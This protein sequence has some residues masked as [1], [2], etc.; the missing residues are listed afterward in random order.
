MSSMTTRVKTPRK[1]PKELVDAIAGLKKFDE[2]FYVNLT[3][4]QRE[5]EYKKQ[6]KIYDLGEK[7]GL[8][9]SYIKE[10]LDQYHTVQVPCHDCKQKQVGVILHGEGG[11]Y[12]YMV[13][14]CSEC[15]E[16]Q[17][18][19][20]WKERKENARIEQL[21]NPIISY[22]YKI[23]NEIPGSEETFQQYKENH[24]AMKEELDLHS[25]RIRDFLDNPREDPE[26]ILK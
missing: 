5:S 25:Q 3:E 11:E 7:L 21:R 9:Y 26:T 13:K 14:L 8:G 2:D 24:A 6:D 4:K 15:E 19:N 20:E 16:K 10:M 23:R 22:C 12:S 18:Y 1:P 17:E